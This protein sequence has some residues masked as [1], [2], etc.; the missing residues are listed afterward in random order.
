MP[1]GSG[2]DLAVVANLPD[3]IVALES[4][5]M[6]DMEEISSNLNDYT[7]LIDELAGARG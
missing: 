5:S 6:F 2:A 7:G 4:E 1:D 3:L